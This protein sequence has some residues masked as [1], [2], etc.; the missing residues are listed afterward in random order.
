MGN[1]GDRLLKK[2]N[3]IEAKMAELVV[4]EKALLETLENDAQLLKEVIGIFLEDSPGKLAELR[5]AVTARN[6][7]QIAIGSHSLRGSISVFGCKAAVEAA[8]N[9]ESIGRQGKVECADEAFSVLEREM[10][11]VTLALH[12]ISKNAF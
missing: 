7:N 8:R 1:L 4:E 10:A 2:V 5:T 9:L 3:I 12:Q 11:L 6:S